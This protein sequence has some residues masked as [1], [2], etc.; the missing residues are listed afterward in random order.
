MAE[1]IIDAPSGFW[2]GSTGRWA[3]EQMLRALQEGREITSSELR[4]L[5]ILRKNEW[6][7]YDEQLVSFAM[8]RLRL[9]AD[10][11]AAGLVRP[12]PN[13]LGK[14]IFQYEK[15][16][17]MNPA[18]ISLDGISRTEDDR[19]EF[20]IAGVPLPIIH[21]DFTLNLRTLSASR[22]RGEP[23]DTM[24][25]QTAGR[26]IAETLE[27]ITINGGPTYGGMPIYGLLN[28]PDANVQ[29]FGAWGQWAGA[30]VTGANILTD[31]LAMFTKLEGDQ[32]YGPYNLYIS[33][34]LSIKLEEDFKA[35]VSQTIRQR[36]MGVDRLN[37]ITV[38]DQMP[39]A[40]GVLVQMTP[41]VISLIDGEPLQ[42]VQWDIEAGFKICF[43]AFTICVPLVRSNANG[44]SGICILRAA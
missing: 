34:D 32:M 35:N 27:Y 8:T 15:M 20:S 31:L 29:N 17:D 4:T 44:E 39:D 24:Q 13:A 9:V 5:D 2:K 19:Q 22:D 42:T 21:K 6:E 18:G 37:S 28:H 23:L 33:H 1:K 25:V 43:K 36:L 16:T 10:L 11:R 14:T 26:K 30:A 12:V 41:D 40:T 3:G 7:Y 38:L